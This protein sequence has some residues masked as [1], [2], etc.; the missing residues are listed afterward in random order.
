M[1]GPLVQRLL[2]VFTVS[3]RRAENAEVKL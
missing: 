2:P 1:I 3:A